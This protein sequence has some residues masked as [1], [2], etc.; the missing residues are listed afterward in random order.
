MHR[1]THSL[2]ACIQSSSCAQVLQWQGV[3]A[4]SAKHTDFAT[5]KE[6]EHAIETLPNPKHV[7]LGMH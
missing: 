5:D 3:V 4:G 7:T 6:L 1:V 2:K